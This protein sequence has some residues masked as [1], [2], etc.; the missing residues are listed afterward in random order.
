MEYKY[1]ATFSQGSEHIIKEGAE[2]WQKKTSEKDG[3]KTVSC[4]HDGDME[5]MNS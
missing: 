5:L 3:N 1:H 2:K 4:V